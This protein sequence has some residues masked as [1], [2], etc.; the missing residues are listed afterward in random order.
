MTAAKLSRR[1]RNLLGKR[2]NDDILNEDII[3]EIDG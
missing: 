3:I 1:N 2:W